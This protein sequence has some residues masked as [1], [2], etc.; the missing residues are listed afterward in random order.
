MKLDIEEKKAIYAF[1]CSSYT[2]TVTRLKWL[3]S[4]TVEPEVKHRMLG[5]VR[6]LEEKGTGEWYYWFYNSVHLEMERY[7][8]LE[9]DLMIIIENTEWEDMADEAV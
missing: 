8:R 2:N 7:F 3:A 5:L 9:R 6:K 1:G 4:F